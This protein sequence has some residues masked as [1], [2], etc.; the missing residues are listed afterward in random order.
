MDFAV[1]L[2]GT[3]G[4]IETVVEF[5]YAITNRENFTTFEEVFFLTSGSIEMLGE[6]AFLL[7]GIGVFFRKKDRAGFKALLK[8]P[9]HNLARGIFEGAA[10]KKLQGEAYDECSC[11]AVMV[12]IL[13]LFVWATYWPVWGS[14]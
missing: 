2:F 12:S 7:M 14:R 3:M 13:S 8:D 10:E 1:Q 5:S 11:L 9:V 4:L 6:V